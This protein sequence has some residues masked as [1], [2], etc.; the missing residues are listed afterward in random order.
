MRTSLL[1]SGGAVVLAAILLRRREQLAA[2]LLQRRTPVQPP[3]PS[4]SAVVSREGVCV[5]K[6]DRSTP[7][8]AEGE[9]LIEVKATAIN[10]LDVMQRKGKT[11]IPAGV[12]EVLGLEAA[13]VVSAVGGGVRDFRVGDEVLALVPGGAYAEYV[14]VDAAT[15]MPKPRWLSWEQAASI[16]E[17]WLTAYKLVHLVGKVAAGETVLIHAAASGVGIAAIQLVTAA[18]AK[19]IVTV[20]S[21]SKL[22]LCV[23]LGALGGAVRHDG[24][25]LPAVSKLAPSG[26]VD[27]VLDCVCASYAAENVEALATDGR[28]VLYSLLSGGALAPE[29]APT[30]LPSLMRKRIQLLA[31]TLRSRSVAYKRR[32]VRAFAAD[33]LPRVGLSPAATGGFGLQHVIDR[34]FH[35]LDA[36]QDAHDYMET[37]G[38]MGK[39]VLSLAG[40]H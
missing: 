14:A 22:D 36:A 32:L 28:W 27:V 5:V 38:N 25:W 17:A 10:R 40:A 4:M 7:T 24:P 23:R 16:P 1:V 12:T 2:L 26:K 33:T 3:R 35:G 31:T 8:P 30:F 29:L 39:I 6:K 9:V 18:G 37:N 20:G 15:V 13:G 34:V 21:R 19:A 11:P